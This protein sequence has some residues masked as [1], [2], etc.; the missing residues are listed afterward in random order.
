V[1]VVPVADSPTS[2]ITEGTKRGWGFDSL[3]GSLQ[4]VRNTGGRAGRVPARGQPLQSE[5]CRSH[6]AHP[7]RQIP[8]LAF[9]SILSLV[10]L[11]RVSPEREERVL[12]RG[13]LLS[14]LRVSLGDPSSKPD[15]IKFSLTAD[16]N[17]SLQRY[18]CNGTR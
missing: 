18:G 4:A 11:R 3:Q 13:S 1:K 16:K 2:T 7:P 12:M 15:E 10:S 14:L 17:H 9:S 6:A 5:H 8:R